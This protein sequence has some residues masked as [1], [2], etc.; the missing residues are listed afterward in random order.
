MPARKIGR[1]ITVGVPAHNEEPHVAATVRSLLAQKLPRGTRM[2]LIV[3]ANA[4]TDGTVRE[5]KKASGRDAR[6]QVIE[7]QKPGKP[8]AMNIITEAAE[9]KHVVFCDADTRVEPQGVAKLVKALDDNPQLHAVSVKFLPIERAGRSWAAAMAG[10]SIKTAPSNSLSGGF[11]AV[12]KDKLPH[13][14]TNVISEDSWLT[15]KL[16]PH[17]W[18]IVPGVRAETSV[19]ST[20]RGVV[21]QR[22]RWNASVLQQQKWGMRK[23]PRMLFDA[24]ERLGNCGKLRLSE[25]ILLLAM[26]PI[27][28]YARLKAKRALVRGEFQR[29][30]KPQR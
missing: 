8:N 23:M 17:E 27:R 26:P 20:L 12:R 9:G 11:M 5:A 21:K 25:K 22:V 28:A 18:A 1:V 4:C 29:G 24:K 16:Q 30:W 19:P 15:R 7:T 10:A 6:V 3:C 13:F 2:Q 14:P